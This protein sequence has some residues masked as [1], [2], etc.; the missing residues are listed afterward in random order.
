MRV[1]TTN[2]RLLRSLV[3]RA[4][5]AYKL[6]A[7]RQGHRVRPSLLVLDPTY[8]CNLRCI[9]CRCPAIS[10]YFDDSQSLTMQDYQRLISQFHTLG[11][12]NIAV[13]GGEPLL[14]SN[15]FEILS[16]ANS[17]NM[18]TSISTNGLLLTK[19]TTKDLIDAGLNQL[20][21]SIDGTG[22]VYDT[23]AGAARFDKL[24]ES[25]EALTQAMKSSGSSSMNVGIHTTVMRHN[26]T[27][28]NDILSLARRFGINDVSFQY[29]SIVSDSINA[30]TEER[31][32][33]KLE[34]TKNHWNIEK[35]L[36]IG[37]ADLVSLRHEVL[38]LKR[39][40]HR[41]GSRISIDPVL[42]DRYD[43]MSIICGNFRL[44]LR[45]TALW[46]AIFVGPNGD[47]SLCPMLTHGS[48]A[49]TRTTRLDEYWHGNPMLKRARTLM[50]KERYLPI[51]GGC[52]NH[53]GLMA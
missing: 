53:I 9:S 14:C 26:V 22:P 45:C 7:L 34:A 29:L 12:R 33:I 35:E 2:S 19:T 18:H 43:E 6:S 36:L 24:V 23:I 3:L 20:T 28:L 5:I 42:D 10:R 52:C 25:L 27:N 47:I 15:I 21:L 39:N 48:V 38:E 11:G 32:G 31:L 4:R 51:C 46:D 41:G 37:R 50:R 40:S 17:Y 1:P 16:C 49:N 13:F 30:A 8:K 44:A